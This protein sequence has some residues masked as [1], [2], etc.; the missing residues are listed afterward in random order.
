M[1]RCFQCEKE[2]P[3]EQRFC[4]HCGAALVLKDYITAQV[5]KAIEE[6]PRDRDALIKA[7]AVEVFEKA[8][9]WAKLTAEILLIPVVA[10]VGLLGW[11][12]WREFNLSKAADNA[13]HQIEITASNARTEISRASTQSVGEVQK[14]SG[15]AISANRNSE[16]TAAKLSN[17]L[18]NTASKTKSELNREATDVR[19]EVAKS[20]AELKSVAELQ[21]EIDL[22][23]VQ[24]GKA[25]TDLVAQQKVLSNSEDFVKQVFSTHVTYLFSFKNFVQP[26]A[27]VLSS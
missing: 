21:P 19:N 6:S 20:K 23:R 24:L 9:G 1:R 8:W 17:E 10:V 15:K 18:K 25:T 14:E 16:Q 5:G 13:Q 4:G 2:N 27:V 22:M 7:N 26:N 11:L 12:G 3:P